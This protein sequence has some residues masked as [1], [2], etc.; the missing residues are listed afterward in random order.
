[1]KPCLTAIAL[2]VA[3]MSTASSDGPLQTRVMRSFSLVFMR[4]EPMGSILDKGQ[5]EASLNWGCSNEYRSIFGVLEDQETSRFGLSY[6]KGLKNLSELAIEVPYIIRSGG[7]LDPIIDWWHQSILGVDTPGRATTPYG[8]CEVALPG[9]HFGSAN[10]L[11]DTRIRFS[12]QLSKHLI[13]SVGV[14]LPT[15]ND[16][17]LLGSGALDA[18]V[19]V[20]ANYPLTNKLTV[21]GQLGWVAQGK[22]TALPHSRDSIVQGALAL[23][24]KVNSR[25]AWIFQWQGEDSAIVTGNPT[26][27]SEHRILSLGYRRKLKTNRWLELYFSEDGDFLDYNAPAIA[28]IGPDFTIGARYTVR[29]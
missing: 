12:K 14:K 23:E 5:S 10:G 19:A 24:L 3:S 28:N 27:D 6:R 1:M 16:G 18:G 22:A 21:Y 4:F 25:D 26:S 7:F 13:C 2:L 15:G 8:R 20:D 9:Y 29:W 11:G 17:G